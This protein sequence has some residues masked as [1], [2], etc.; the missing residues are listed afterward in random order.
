MFQPKIVFFS[1]G[2]SGT[3]PRGFCY[4]QVAV[5]CTTPTRHHYHHFPTLSLEHLHLSLPAYLVLYSLLTEAY[6]NVPR[7]TVRGVR[8]TPGRINVKNRQRVFSTGQLHRNLTTRTFCKKW[9]ISTLDKVIY[10]K[11]T[12]F[13]QSTKPL[14]T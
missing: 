5:L 7:P 12:I 1:T 4:R 6:L 13:Q 3:V 11:G 8:G 9:L 2:I 10:F 14:F